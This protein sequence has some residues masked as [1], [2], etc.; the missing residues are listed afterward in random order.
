MTFIAAV[1]G[2]HFYRAV[3]VA[4]GASFACLV[5]V[6]AIRTVSM[7]I[8]CGMTYLA[9]A[10][11]RRLPPCLRVGNRIY[12]WFLSAVGGG[13][14]G[15]DEVEIGGG[16]ARHIVTGRTS[17]PI[18]GFVVKSGNRRMDRQAYRR[19]KQDRQK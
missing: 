19:R 8:C 14:G 12:H 5:G 15:G 13:N 4:I 10:V 6:I 3:Q 1:A 18:V 7:V 11:I 16:T 9:D 17:G 2:N